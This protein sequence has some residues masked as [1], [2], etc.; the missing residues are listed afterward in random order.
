M[1]Y[2]SE[3][4][5]LS[6]YKIV[7]VV[8]ASQMMQVLPASYCPN[9]WLIK[10]KK[11]WLLYAFPS[12]PTWGTENTFPFTF[13]FL[14]STLDLCLLMKAYWMGKRYSVWT[15]GH[16]FS[17]CCQDPVPREKTARQA[18]GTHSLSILSRMGCGYTSCIP[19]GLSVTST[20]VNRLC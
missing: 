20:W 18:Y 12:E 4:S 13:V 1:T 8:A 16:H 5:S 2:A 10:A 17:K 6:I 14:V 3:V 15:C 19:S 7:K 9:D 11:A